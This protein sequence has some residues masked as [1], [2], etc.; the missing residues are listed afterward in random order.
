[1]RRHRKNDVLFE[2]YDGDVTMKTPSIQ[3]QIFWKLLS[4]IYTVSVFRPFLSVF[5]RFCFLKKY[6]L[7]HPHFYKTISALRR[8]LYI[9]ENFVHKFCVWTIRTIFQ[10]KAVPPCKKFF[11]D[12]FC[13]VCDSLIS[14]DMDM[15]KCRWKRTYLFTEK[16]RRKK[17]NKNGYC[18]NSPLVNTNS[19]CKF[20]VPVT[21]GLGVR[22]GAFLSLSPVLNELAN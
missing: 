15:Q 10:N 17:T 8:L 2:K 9:D 7:F 20:G 4:W 18:V 14:A 11:S 22:L 1:M 3:N 21:F 19:R 13:P 5:L 16:Q 6:A 12:N